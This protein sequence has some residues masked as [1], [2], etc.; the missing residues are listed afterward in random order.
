MLMQEEKE[1]RG[2]KKTL[3]YPG[4]IKSRVWRELGLKLQDQSAAVGVSSSVKG[5]I[6]LYLTDKGVCSPPHRWTLRRSGA[7]VAR[8]TSCSSP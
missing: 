3:V 5:E 1:L 7:D 6:S 8:I 4:S 2:K